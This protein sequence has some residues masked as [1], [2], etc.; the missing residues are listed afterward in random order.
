[1]DE[2]S[3][4]NAPLAE[5]REDRNHLSIVRQDI[6]EEVNGELLNHSFKRPQM[7]PVT[8]LHTNDVGRY[9]YADY[10][11][12]SIVRGYD[13]S[14]GECIH[15]QLWNPVEEEFRGFESGS[16]MILIPSN[17]QGAIRA[18]LIGE[19][20][21]IKG[22][23]ASPQSAEE[24]LITPT[25][26][27]LIGSQ[28][29]N[30]YVHYAKNWKLKRILQGGKHGPVTAMALIP[31]SSRVVVSFAD[32]HVIVF[33][34]NEDIPI[35]TWKIID[36][37]FRYL[38]A[39]DTHFCGSTERDAYWVPFEGGMVPHFEYE[40]RITQL[41]VGLGDVWSHSPSRITQFHRYDDFMCRHI[42]IGLENGT[43]SIIDFSG[44]Q[45]ITEIEGHKDKITSMLISPERFVVTGSADGTI[46]RIDAQQNKCVAIYYQFDGNRNIAIS[47]DAKRL[48]ISGIM[49]DTAKTIDAES[50]LICHTAIHQNSVRCVHLAE[51]NNREVL[52]TGGWDGKVNLWDARTGE[53]IR[54]FEISGNICDIKTIQNYLIVGYYSA[55]KMGGF[56]VW[57][58]LSN[59]LVYVCLEHFPREE[60]GRAI[61]LLTDDE[62]IYSCGDDGYVHKWNLGNKNRLCSFYHGASVRSLAILGDKSR[63]FSSSIDSTIIEWNLRTESA[64]RTLRGHH[65]RVYS[66][67]VTRDDRLLFSGDEFGV[68]NK[69]D[70]Q[71]GALIESLKHHERAR[72]WK[73]ELSPDGNTLVSA[74]EDGTVKFI[75][76]STGKLLGTYYNLSKG[77]LW[78]IPAAPKGGSG[79]YWTNRLDLINI[80]KTFKGKK[81]PEKDIDM[82]QIREYHQVY[83]NQKIVM[84]RIN[85][86]P[87]SNLFDLSSTKMSRLLDLDKFT[88]SQNTKKLE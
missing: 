78:T 6:L 86:L 63:L 1:M 45:S 83:N 68:I 71:S 61:A 54:S 55:H 47:S 36:S 29:G 11:R 80:E 74:C 67:V 70:V 60:F 59:N 44:K 57:D 81:L 88:R 56:G 49:D 48:C 25:K 5:K 64:E 26:E 46:R 8:G 41:K 84:S 31:F 51:L 18:F 76:I 52:F 2:A 75:S 24:V 37:P 62:Y 42:F 35:F 73:L 66:M 20:K 72:I 58:L 27:I 69:F 50:G 17:E 21:T 3:M 14:T 87:Y 38:S 30:V 53:L 85:N 34:V 10:Q 7:L 40:Q 22:I 79:Y 4:E 9:I 12:G 39:S 77:F 82:S 15:E 16:T 32:G 33:D 43:V 19:A 65:G 13:I 28:D 23:L